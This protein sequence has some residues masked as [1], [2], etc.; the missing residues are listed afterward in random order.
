MASGQRDQMKQ[1]LSAV[2][3]LISILALSSMPVHALPNNG[4]AVPD[5]IGCGVR[6]Q[7]SRNV[8]EP[9]ALLAIEPGRDLLC[10][11][12]GAP[13]GDLHTYNLASPVQGEAH[14]VID[15]PC[16]IRAPSVGRLCVQVT[17]D[18]TISGSGTAHALSE[19]TGGAGLTA[20]CT[21]TSSGGYDTCQDLQRGVAETPWH[22]KLDLK[23]SSSGW[24][25][26]GCSVTMG[27]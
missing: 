20:Q 10:T 16:T 18:A 15:V 22:C 7:V 4:C 3:V 23:L 27:P 25:S 19:C 13:I 26:A 5:P 2:V 24:A 17:A 6:F 11:F 21:A 9:T 1:T 14:F 12:Q 8:G